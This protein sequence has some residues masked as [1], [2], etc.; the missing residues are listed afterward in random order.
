MDQ[1]VFRKY[2]KNVEQ[3]IE[4]KNVSAAFQGAEMLRKLPFF[5]QKL[6]MK[7][8]T[9]KDPYMGFVVEP[10]SLFLSYEI[11]HKDVEHFLPKNY[12]LLPSSIFEES[13]KKHCAIIGLFNIHTDVFWGSRFEI[14]V[15]ARNKDTNLATW[16]I[17]DYESN[18]INFDPGEG[19]IAPTL[20]KSVFTSTHNGEIIT[21]FENVKTSNCIRLC[22][23]IKNTKFKPLDKQLWIEGNLSVDY[24]G[25][26]GDESS[27]PFGLIFDP[28]EMKGTME[29][30]PDNI[31]IEKLNFGFI[32]KDST[33][34][35]ACCFPYAQHFIT[36]TI[37]KG[38]EMKNETDLENKIREIA[39]E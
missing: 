33:L 9:K 18:T 26:L 2:V 19:F 34:L 23:D 27:V 30:K 1:H 21:D 12:E 14:Y 5:I 28:E 36:T 29:I 11:T 24:S 35:E 4:P 39:E 8:V 13:P 17:Y 10:W 20:S 15:I 6:I 7:S 16:I 22:A 25:E 31:S 37:P 32:N 3:R 38:H